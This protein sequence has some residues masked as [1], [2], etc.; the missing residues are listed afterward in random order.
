MARQSE[1]AFDAA[2]FLGRRR[3]AVYEENIRKV[4]PG[5]ETLHTMA[6]RLIAREIGKAGDVLI[7]GAGAGEELINF[8]QWRPDWKLTGIDPS[9]PMIGIAQDR[10]ERAGHS[11]SIKLQQGYVDDLP[12]DQQ[13]DAAT[14]L[15]VMHFLADNGAKE[16]ILSEIAKRLKT[17]APFVIADFNGDR[18]SP[19]IEFM[20]EAWRDWQLN[21]GI[22]P[23]HVEGAIA[24]IRRDISF[25]PEQRIKELLEK[26]GF[27]QPIRIY[28]AYFLGAWIAYK[29]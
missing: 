25:V 17:G 6:A 3:S 15:L 9:G 12:G 16:K 4:T 2:L 27:S 8:S 10:I 19:E 13:F 26:S 1:D 18:T 29:E 28:S 5:Y 20:I 14:L 11:Q 23:E 24:H 22:E 7:T 21:E